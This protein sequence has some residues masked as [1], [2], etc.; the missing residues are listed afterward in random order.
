MPDATI[1][2]LRSFHT[3]PV[4]N[5]TEKALKFKVVENEKF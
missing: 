5:K 2:Q 1:T 3:V 4:A